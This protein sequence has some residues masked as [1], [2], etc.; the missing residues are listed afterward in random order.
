MIPAGGSSS[1]GE[2]PAAPQEEPPAAPQEAQAD[3]G[4]TITQ[5]IFEQL[6]DMVELRYGSKVMLLWNGVGTQECQASLKE[7][8]QV[9]EDCLQRLRVDFGAD[10]YMTLESMDVRAWAGATGPRQLALRAK[11]RQLCEAL[12]VTFTWETWRDAIRSVERLRRKSPDPENMDNRILWTHAL[13]ASRDEDSINIYTPLVTFF[14]S[15]TDGTGSIERYLGSHASF[16]EHHQGGP[17]NHMAEVCLEIAKEGPARE[18]LLFHKDLD[19]Q[20]VLLLTPW[21]R[22]CCQ[23]WR[24]LHG[25]RFACY[26]ERKDKGKRHTEW[27]LKGSMKAVGLMQEQATKALVQMAASDHA[28]GENASPRRK[29]LLGVDRDQLMQHQSRREIAAPTKALKN[30]RKTTNDRKNTKEK[31]SCWPGF[32]SQPP[33]M[34][35]KQG[36]TSPTMVGTSTKTPVASQGS[37]VGRFAMLVAKRKAEVDKRQLLSSKRPC[38]EN[39]RATNVVV[40]SHTELYT[41]FLDSKALLAWLPAIALGLPTA[42]EK[43]SATAASQGHQ[44]VPGIQTAAK[45]HFTTEFCRKHPK[46][47]NVFRQLIAKQ[48]SRWTQTSIAEPNCTVISSLKECQAF[49][50]KVRTLPQAAGVHASFLTESSQKAVRKLSRYGRPPSTTPRGRPAISK[51]E[52]ASSAASSARPSWVRRPAIAQAE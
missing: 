41:T 33:L 44:H 11:A 12:G 15:I 20:G 10:L 28:V 19:C 34:R 42:T 37:K 3:Q 23:L 30:F 22:K 29:T 14:A 6:A 21:S 8:G 2:P 43:D 7:I 46:L 17:D 27:R 49:L 9:V 36:A 32:G 48:S 45:L 13:S 51:I 5:I 50:R 52:V 40:K 35:K 1:S 24:G 18:D 26:K 47:L 38:A 16:L 31:S 25:R 39:S 4:K